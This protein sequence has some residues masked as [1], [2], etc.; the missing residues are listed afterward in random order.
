MSGYKSGMKGADVVALLKNGLPIVNDVS[1]LDPNAELGSMASVVTAGSIQE[2]SV[3][4]LYQPDASMIDQ[5]T[6]TLTQPELLSSVSSIKVFAPTDINNIGFEFVESGF[7]L[8]TRDFSETNQNMAMIYVVPEGVTGR[9][10]VGG[11]NTT[12]T[13]VF[14]EFLS[15]TNSF[16]I[17]DDQVEA[18]NAI[19]ANGMDW[20]YFAL[21]ESEIGLTEEQFNTIDLFVN[22]V[23][24]VPS[25]AHV[26]LKND[27]WEELHAKDF[28]KLSR[29]IDKVNQSILDYSFT[30]IENI[31]LKDEAYNNKWYVVLKDNTIINV[32]AS[33]IIK[34]GSS[35]STIEVGLPSS[36]FST[37]GTRYGCVIKGPNHEWEINLNVN[38][39]GQNDEELRHLHGNEIVYLQ[40]LNYGTLAFFTLEYHITNPLTWFEI[41]FDK[42][43]MNGGSAQWTSAS[44]DWKH[45]YD[46][47]IN[48]NR[49]TN[50]YF[51]YQFHDNTMEVKALID[52]SLKTIQMISYN[53]R[54]MVI[55]GSTKNIK[56]GFYPRGNDVV[57]TIIINEHSPIESLIFGGIYSTAVPVEKLYVNNI[58][59]FITANLNQPAALSLINTELYSGGTLYDKSSI[60]I[61]NEIVTIGARQFYQTNVIS[62]VFANSVSLI[63]EEAFYNCTLMQYCDFSTHNSIPTLE[64]SAFG[65]IPSTCKIIVPDALYDEWIAATNWSDIADHIIKK[66]DWDASQVTE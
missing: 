30:T 38:I 29:N 28:E 41:G 34:S 15:D 55:R 51:P 58:S 24:D 10:M 9:T 5:T 36:P 39:G 18:F 2:T 22:T 16:I 35:K 42:T 12:Q 66:S 26:Y 53:P 52:N 27:N 17:H 64:S 40:L 25:K 7:Y 21:P 1:E 13:F 63:K 46:L 62:V 23:S 32:D 11:Y 19:L 47:L 4:N 49:P 44:E 65:G 6:G 37:N 56:F 20:C 3:R 50:S 14:V 45:Y 8:V 33:T 48:G 54:T 43:G 57:P 60:I 59:N 31:T 61:P